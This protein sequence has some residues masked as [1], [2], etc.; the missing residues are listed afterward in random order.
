M[1]LCTGTSCAVSLLAVF[2]FS[3][4]S[5]VQKPWKTDANK[6]QQEYGFIVLIFTA[7]VVL[8]RSMILHNCS[9]LSCLCW[10]CYVSQSEG[11][12][13]R[14]MLGFHFHKHKFTELS[15]VNPS[16]LPVAGAVG[17]P[18]SNESS[19]HTGWLTFHKLIVIQ[20]PVLKLFLYAYLHSTLGYSSWMFRQ[21][22]VLIWWIGSIVTRS[23]HTTV[24][25]LDRAY[26]DLISYLS[27][28]IT[29]SEGTADHHQT[30][31]RESKLELCNWTGSVWY[32]VVSL[33]SFMFM[34]N[35]W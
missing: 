25:T 23:Y 3:C 14:G 8:R 31:W 17:M 24:W 29:T 10:V 18:H 11:L 16:L 27:I 30:L 15:W 35:M 28:S 9:H 32:D 20:G 6:N 12:L 22:G 4:R 2:V 34:Y 7:R 33:F 1:V 21:S 26:H 19:L 13:H 5:F